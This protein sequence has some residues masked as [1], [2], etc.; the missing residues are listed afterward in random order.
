MRK[1]LEEVDSGKTI[2][3]ARLNLLIDRGFDILRRAAREILNFD[4]LR[5]N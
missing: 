4:E 3:A 1:V 5:K 2:K